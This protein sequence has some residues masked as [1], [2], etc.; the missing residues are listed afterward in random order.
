M[1]RSEYYRQNASEFLRQ[2]NT[3]GPVGTESST[4]HS[5]CMGDNPPTSYWR[6]FGKD[7]DRAIRS[8]IGSSLREMYSDLVQEPLPPK[9][10][11]LL[12]RLGQE[13]QSGS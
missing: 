12:R 1:L 9:I 13:K 2:A 10:A 8:R 4:P 11:D 7:A 6:I 3:Q 5:G